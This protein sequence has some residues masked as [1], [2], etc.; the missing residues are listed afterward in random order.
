MQAD[1]V[2]LAGR[3]SYRPCSQQT[4]VGTCRLRHV[5]VPKHVSTR[6]FKPRLQDWCTYGSAI[7]EALLTEELAYTSQRQ[8]TCALLVAAEIPGELAHRYVTVA[9]R[10]NCKAA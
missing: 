10:Q 5:A 6:V 3:P 1:V 7:Y 4:S 9:G 2:L 8:Q